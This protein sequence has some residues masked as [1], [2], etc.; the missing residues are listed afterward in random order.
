M[1][2]IEVLKMLKNLG[3]EAYSVGGYP[4]DILRGLKPKD[5]DFTTPHLPNDV[6]EK[7]GDKVLKK[8]TKKTIKYGVVNFIY[9]NEIFE[10]TTFR[11]DLNKTR[12][13]EVSFEASMYEDAIRRDFT[14]NAIY[15][16]I[17]GKFIDPTAKGINDIK[18]KILRTIGPAIDRFCEDGS[19]ILRM[20][21][22]MCDFYPDNS[23]FET[24]TLLETFDIFKKVP[25]EKIT[26]EF[27]K[28]LFSKKASEIIINLRNF[29]YLELI[30]PELYETYGFDQ[31]TKYHHFNLFNHL[32][33]TVEFLQNYEKASSELVL[34]GLLHDIGKVHTK[35]WSEKKKGATYIN[36][37]TVGSEIAF[38]ILTRLKLS[39]KQIKKIVFLINNHMKLHHASNV[40]HYRRIRYIVESYQ[41]ANN[42]DGNL[43]QDL[44]LLWMADNY[45]KNLR[46]VDYPTYPEIPNNIVSS[47]EVIDLIKS[48]GLHKKY[49]GLAIKK[50]WFI[51]LKNP[52]SQTKKSILNSVKSYI[53]SHIKKQEV[54]IV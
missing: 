35:V 1:N 48:M 10:I 18:S 17:N 45:G 2:D 21:R 33:Y 7:L 14:I 30:I 5:I 39:K 23:L 43:L 9:K 42:L 53:K 52:Y 31:Q 44:S 36:H 34:A 11:K 3:I 13:T 22:F 12:D 41:K 19:R 54:T 24:I 32:L 51:F 6:Y 26:K 27:M 49:Y 47:Q 38:K 37:E 46:I 20:F 50:S 25:Q 29:C 4:R 28:I 8:L 40:K 16:D 15:R